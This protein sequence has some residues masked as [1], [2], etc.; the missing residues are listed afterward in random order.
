MSVLTSDKLSTLS[1]VKSKTTDYLGLT[2]EQHYTF[3]EGKF[4]IIV[5]RGKCV[6]Y[7][8][9]ENNFHGNIFRMFLKAATLS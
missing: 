6:G 7:R 1:S 8:I 2:L 5:T 4:C 3:T 9:R